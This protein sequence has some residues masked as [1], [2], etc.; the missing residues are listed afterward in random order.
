MKQFSSGSDTPLSAGT[1]AGGSLSDQLTDLLQYAVLAPSI[2]NT[3]PWQFGVTDDAVEFYLDSSRQLRVA[4]PEG[5]EAT[6]SIGAAIF[7]LRLAMRVHGLEPTLAYH[8]DPI[9]RNH[10]ATVQ[11]VGECVPD[12]WERELLALVPLRHATPGPME[13]IDLSPEERDWLSSHVSS[14]HGF[15][16]WMSDRELRMLV[17]GVIREGERL[18]FHDPHYR[19]E[20]ASWL[21][22]NSTNSPDGITAR[23]AGFGPLASGAAPWLVRTFDVGSIMAEHD[24]ALAEQAP[25]LAILWT[26]RDEVANWLDAGEALCRLELVATKLG[27]EFSVFNQPLQVPSIRDRL[28][29]EFGSSGS[30]QAIVRIGIGNKEQHQHRRRSRVA[31]K[32][33]AN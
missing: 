1:A 3:Q 2:L 24:A 31:V 16:T 9:H 27:M 32:E 23:Q 10:L 13:A 18:L 30:P 17:I 19:D 26:G 14:E 29:H 6:I 25:S 8:F 7:L 15:L 22:P 28:V 21:R 4:D 5:R 20:F 12:E 33:S 11:C